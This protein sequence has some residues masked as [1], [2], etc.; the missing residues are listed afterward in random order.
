MELA[1]TH[2]TILCVELKQSMN[3][4][5]TFRGGTTG[6]VC[7]PGSGRRLVGLSTS[8]PFSPSIS[9]KIRLLRTKPLCKCQP[10]NSL[11]LKITELPC[12]PL[13]LLNDFLYEL[14]LFNFHFFTYVVIDNV[15]D[16]FK[17]IDEHKCHHRR[18]CA[19]RRSGRGPEQPD[20]DD[21]GDDAQSPLQ[22]SPLPR[23]EGACRESK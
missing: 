6:N 23:H 7:Q 9:L 4:E 19:S 11:W 13:C 17:M 5:T 20:A 22:G 12:F 10:V 8:K 2:F 1:G 15:C 3:R 21:G 14:T 18:W 16:I